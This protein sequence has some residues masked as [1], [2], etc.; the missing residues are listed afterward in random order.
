MVLNEI[1]KGG[2][3]LDILGMVHTKIDMLHDFVIDVIILL[4][5]IPSTLPR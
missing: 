5:A 3:N 4:F 2:N 1:V